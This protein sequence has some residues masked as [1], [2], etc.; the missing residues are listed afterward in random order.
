MER[1]VE[2]GFLSLSHSETETDL[3]M[4]VILKDESGER[5]RRKGE[6][7]VGSRWVVREKGL[8]LGV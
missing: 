5:R 3:S 7:G 1:G 6:A 4:P 2:R 8:D